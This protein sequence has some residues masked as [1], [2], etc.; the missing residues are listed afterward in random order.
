[1]TC[2]LTLL[3]PR[4]VSRR[5]RRRLLGLHGP[6]PGHLTALL[7]GD[8]FRVSKM[9]FVV[10]RRAWEECLT[11]LIATPRSNQL[12]SMSASW[13]G[14]HDFREQLNPDIKG[15]EP[16]EVVFCCAELRRK[17]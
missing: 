13:T 12:L 14:I 4:P 6:T 9:N 15:G 17:N 1:M 10:A 2:L 7:I 3:L 16:I 11:P 5:S 8:E